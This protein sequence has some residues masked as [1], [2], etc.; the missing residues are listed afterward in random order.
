MGRFDYTP[1]RDMKVHPA[2]AINLLCRPFQSHEN[3]LPEWLKNSSD[4]YARS[5]APPEQRVIVLLFNALGTDE[6]SIAVLDFCGMTSGASTSRFTVVSSAANN[7]LLECGGLP[8]LCRCGACPAVCH[9]PA[10]SRRD[11]E[12]RQGAALQTRVW[13]LQQ[14]PNS[15]N[16]P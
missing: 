8:P 6:A 7:R 4:A 13:P 15:V 14:Q 10:A 5:D 1:D 12:R 2:G 3:G 11:P 16:Q 9:P